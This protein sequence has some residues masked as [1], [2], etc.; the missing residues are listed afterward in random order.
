MFTAI[1]KSIYIFI[2]TPFI[3]GKKGEKGESSK[4][5]IAIVE[6]TV[7]NLQKNTTEA[8]GNCTTSFCFYKI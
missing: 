4:P 8:L 3:V 6:K 7:S 1:E 2:Y 5:E